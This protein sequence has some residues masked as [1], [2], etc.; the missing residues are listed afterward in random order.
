MCCVICWLVLGGCE[1]DS[2]MVWLMIGLSFD[3][4]VVYDDVFLVF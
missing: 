2:L 1:F 4:D 3:K